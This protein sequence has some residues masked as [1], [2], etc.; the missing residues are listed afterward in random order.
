MGTSMAKREAE[1]LERQ[2]VERERQARE[3]LVRRL[4]EAAKV[5]M[6]AIKEDEDRLLFNQP[7]HIVP[8][9]KEKEVKVYISR[10]NDKY[11]PVVKD[12]G[13]LMQGSV[14]AAWVWNDKF[15]VV[16]SGMMAEMRWGSTWD[17]SLKRWE[18]LLQGT[19]Q[20]AW[21]WDGTL[22]VVRD[23]MVAVTEFG[24][25]WNGQLQDWGRIFHGRVTAAWVADEKLYVI[26]GSKVAITAWG[27]EWN[28]HVEDWVELEGNC[29][30]AFVHENN[31]YVVKS[32]Q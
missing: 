20:A 24:G 30:T 21:V 27:Q 11:A 3:R 9:V 6:L 7:K 22:Y 23:G 10:W 25:R 16:K 1:E 26:K 12:W 15:Y 31:L 5:E 17:G 8:A 13:P 32:C 19:V 14:Q 18:R 28:G 2:V 29:K 4:E